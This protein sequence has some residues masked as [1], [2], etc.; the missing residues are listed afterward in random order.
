VLSTKIGELNALKDRVSSSTRTNNVVESKKKGVPGRNKLSP[1][2][3]AVKPGLAQWALAAGRNA[4]AFRLEWVGCPGQSKR[5][6]W[7]VCG[8]PREGLRQASVVTGRKIP[9]KPPVEKS[10]PELP[11]LGDLRQ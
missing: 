5:P 9:I 10:R 7:P 8:R 4:G 11:R 3:L 6:G 1:R 2:I